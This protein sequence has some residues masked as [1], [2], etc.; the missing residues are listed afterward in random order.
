MEDGFDR[1]LVHSNVVPNP[2]EKLTRTPTLQDL[3]EDSKQTPL[4]LPL[5][6]HMSPPSATFQ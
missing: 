6:I 4:K 3:N 2:P 5:H 1:Y